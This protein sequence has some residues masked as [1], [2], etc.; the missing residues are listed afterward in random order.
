MQS[1][2]VK[3]KYA[4][5]K[6]NCNSNVGLFVSSMTIHNSLLHTKVECP[7]KKCVYCNKCM[8]F[9][10]LIQWLF[11]NVDKWAQKK[12]QINDHKQFFFFASP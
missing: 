12:P 5:K 2:V 8:F 4:N 3:I 9:F 10:E 7:I 11:Y 1:V 6:V